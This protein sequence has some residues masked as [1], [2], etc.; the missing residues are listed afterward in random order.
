MFSADCRIAARTSLWDASHQSSAPKP[1]SRYRSNCRLNRR[2]SRRWFC[3]F[4]ADNRRYSCCNGCMLFFLGCQYFFFRVLFLAAKNMCDPKMHCVAI[5]IASSC[6]LCLRRTRTTEC[7]LEK[8]TYR[9]CRRCVFLYYQTSAH[10]IC[11]ACRRPGAFVVSKGGSSRMVSCPNLWPYLVVACQGGCCVVVLCVVI[12]FASVLGNLL[13]CMF[14][15]LC[16]GVGFFGHGLLVFGV[17]CMVV[18]A[19]LGYCFGG[20]EDE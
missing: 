15:F 7:A 19:L 1:P 13:S 4:S 18:F 12:G 9:L 3:L 17:S 10:K 6:D 20:S 2:R 14:G 8:C 11:P 16:F 5:C